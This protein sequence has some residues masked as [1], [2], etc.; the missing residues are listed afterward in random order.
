MSE[1]KPAAALDP[2]EL[3]EYTAPL[4]YTDRERDLV[5]SVNG[6]TIRILRGVPVHIKRKYLE[7]LENAQAQTDAARQVMA[8]AKERS[9]KA[10]ASF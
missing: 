4:L 8:E 9:S 2:E 6:E 1:K 5:V 10:L 7:V 3:V